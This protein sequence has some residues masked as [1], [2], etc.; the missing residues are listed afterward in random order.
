MSQGTREMEP[1]SPDRLTNVTEL[2]QETAD[3]HAFLNRDN[4]FRPPLN[5]EYL[6]IRMLA[7]ANK[8]S[9]LV[10]IADAMNTVELSHD[11]PYSVS[12]NKDLL[13]DKNF[14]KRVFDFWDRTQEGREWFK[15][16]LVAVISKNK[17]AIR[18]LNAELDELIS[19]IVI[20]PS[21]TWDG[22]SLMREDYF[23][24]LSLAGAI[25]YVLMLLLDT[26]R[27]LNSKLRR[28]KLVECQHF[29]LS[30]SSGGRPPLYCSVHCKS[31]SD[32]KSSAERTRKWRKNKT[33]KRDKS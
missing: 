28:C 24:S 21:V 15:H 10:E 17:K 13:D 32:G 19:H 6:V 7:L 22:K 26:N 11:H 8:N 4:A 2:L 20:V 27:G 23:Y 31:I 14:R 5:D 30:R 12:G 16:Q 25:A 18:A 1:V 3:A 9:S 29:F 33:N